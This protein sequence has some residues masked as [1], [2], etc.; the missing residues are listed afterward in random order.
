LPDSNVSGTFSADRK[1]CSYASGAMVTFATALTLPL[2]DNPTWDFTVSSGG[3]TCLH[4]VENAGGALSLTVGGQTFHEAPMG[5]M[6][7]AV[8]CPDGKRYSTENAFNL[9]ACGGNFLS[10]LP[11]SVWSTS[12]TALSF[13]L[14]GTSTSSDQSLS[15]FDC[16]AP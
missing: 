7:L 9:L 15:V 13:G 12:G 16:Q 11:G 2:P 8:T 14:I 5:S 6:G 10:G 3:Q 4:Y 1:T